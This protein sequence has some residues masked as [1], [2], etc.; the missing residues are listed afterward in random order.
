MARKGNV[1]SPVSSLWDSEPQGKPMGCRVKEAG[2]S[3]SHSVM[4]WIGIASDQYYPA[5][6]RADFPLVFRYEKV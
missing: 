6:K 1:V 3:E 5:R 4:G 2:Q